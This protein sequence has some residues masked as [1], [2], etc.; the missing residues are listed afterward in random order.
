MPG[1]TL[2]FFKVKLLKINQK[3]KI[4]NGHRTTVSSADFNG[5]G[6]E[7]SLKSRADLPEP[8][9]IP[10]SCPQKAGPPL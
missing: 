4:K 2:P 7:I 5:W 8:P 3:K 9:I 10:G 6:L 1:A